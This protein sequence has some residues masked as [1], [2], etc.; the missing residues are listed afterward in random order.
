MI[1]NKKSSLVRAETLKPGLQDTPVWLY[2]NKNGW[3]GFSRHDVIYVNKSE[4]EIVIH[5]F[6]HRAVLSF[7]K[8]NLL[9]YR[10]E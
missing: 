8:F 1:K 2:S 10:V 5:K 9:N 3:E 7:E 6:G 4:R